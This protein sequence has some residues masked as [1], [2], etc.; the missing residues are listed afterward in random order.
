LGVRNL[1]VLPVVRPAGD[2]GDP[3]DGAVVPTDDLVT[4]TALREVLGAVSHAYPLILIDA[5]AKAPLTPEAV[6]AADLVVLVTLATAADLESVLADLENPDGQLAHLGIRASEPPGGPD[7]DGPAADAPFARTGR[8]A[9]IAA[10]VSPRRGRPSPRTRTA[11]ARLASQVDGMVRIPYDPRLDPSRRTP[12]R[13]PRLR[14]ATRRACLRLAATAVDTLIAL[15]E[16]ETRTMPAGPPLAPGSPRAEHAIP[17]ASSSP[18]QRATDHP[19]TPGVSFGDL[20][21]RGKT[22]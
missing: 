10:V 14:W 8:P 22:R 5:P 7:A 17:S 4:P 21:P 19:S 13:I 18:Q 9:V 12:V 1:D 20:R 2:P 15:A 11:A 16:A 6:H 3:A